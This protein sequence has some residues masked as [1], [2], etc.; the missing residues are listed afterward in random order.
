[1]ETSGKHHIV[2]LWGSTF[3]K[4]ND[5]D[6]IRKT[7]IQA[8][9]KA[10]VDIREK[11]FHRFTPHGL[12]GVLVLAESHLSIHTFPEHGYASVDIYTCG[13]SVNPSLAIDHICE[14]LAATSV[15]KLE[16]NRGEKP[17]RIIS[18]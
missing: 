5:L 17:M 14:Q 9:E 7:L 3:D 13:D 2:E 12:S 8:A 11:I 6:F 18:H 4:L 1:M 10:G 15:E 16:I